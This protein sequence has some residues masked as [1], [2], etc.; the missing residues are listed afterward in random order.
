MR[1]VPFA[2]YDSFTDKAFGGSQVA[3]VS[4]AAD[5]NSK[6]RSLIAKELGFPATCFVFDYDDSSITAHFH[7][8][9]QEYYMCGHGTVALMTRMIDMGILDWQER[10]K[11]NIDLVINSTVAPVEIF[12]KKDGSALVM[13]D[14]QPPIFETEVPEV[15]KLAPL[16]GLTVDDYDNTLSIEKACSAFNHLIV[17]I[18]SIEAMGSIKPD[19]KKLR[20]FCLDNKISTVAAFCRGAS[21]A[22]YDIHMRDFCP[23]VGV[24]ESGATGTTNAALSSY[25]I[26]YN[27]VQK[28]S[29]SQFNV[30]TEQG[31]EIGRPSTI[32]SVISMNGDSIERLQ[33]GGVATKIVGGDFFLPMDE[34]EIKIGQGLKEEPLNTRLEPRKSCII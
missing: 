2:I 27:L 28:N 7:S 20:T 34:Q 10:G 30:T 17:P 4:E 25:L 9:E 15:K 3:I 29:D 32:R 18:R 22:G 11:M 23:A 24:N 21:Q 12:R 31:L 19:F 26:R 6:T 5:M 16:L 1:T 13:L 14:I 33:V 8:T